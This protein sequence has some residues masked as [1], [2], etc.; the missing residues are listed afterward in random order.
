M[1]TY[2]QEK[3]E[4]VIS[5]LLQKCN[6]L[7]LDMKNATAD[8]AAYYGI[9]PEAAI[10]K[11]C[12]NCDSELESYFKQGAE[13]TWRFEEEKSSSVSNEI[14]HA[15]EP[16]SKMYYSEAA[17]WFSFDLDKGTAYLIYQMGPRYVRSLTYHITYKGDNLVE[18]SE[19]ATV[20]VG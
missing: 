2:N 13:M 9:P 15:K 1:K 6:L 12:K 16:I 10:I 17:F 7:F 5:A 11:Y 4:S 19:E 18:L 3:E 20:W 8:E 14:C